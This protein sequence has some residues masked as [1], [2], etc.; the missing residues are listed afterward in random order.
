MKE[1]VSGLVDAELDRDSTDTVLRE[2]TQDETLRAVW[3]RYHLI[4]AALKHEVSGL[5]GASVVHR[6]ADA[7]RTEPTPAVQRDNIV[8]FPLRALKPA[9]G[10]AIA[11][12]VAAAVVFGLLPNTDFAPET[13]GTVAM[14][15]SINEEFP[16]SATRWQTISPE[17]EKVL[18]AYLVEHGE[19]SAPSGLTGLTSYARF[20][21]YDADE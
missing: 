17:M 5:E 16:T 15:T 20:V 1:K 18:N 6:V 13:G 12:S 9:A 4:G 10:F 14:Q 2:L 21:S 7:I 11:A 8:P 3:D 19:F